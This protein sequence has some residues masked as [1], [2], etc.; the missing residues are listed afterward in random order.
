MLIIAALTCNADAKLKP[1]IK[2]KLLSYTDKRIKIEYHKKIRC[3]GI[4]NITVGEYRKLDKH[5]G[6]NMELAV[7]PK[8]IKKCTLF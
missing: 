4:K 1:I 8:D 2:V 7:T 3:V 5:I 6:K